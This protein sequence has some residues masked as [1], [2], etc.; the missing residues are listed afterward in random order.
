M[1]SIN[2]FFENL[3]IPINDQII[4]NL[5]DVYTLRNCTGTCKRWKIVVN[6]FLEKNPALKTEFNLIEK[7]KKSYSIMIEGFKRFESIEFFDHNHNKNEYLFRELNRELN[8]DSLK[9]KKVEVIKRFLVLN[10]NNLQ[11]ELKAQISLSYKENLDL[12]RF[13]LEIGI[14]PIDVNSSFNEIKNFIVEQITKHTKR[15]AFEVKDWI[16]LYDFDLTQ[17][18]ENSTK[19]LLE[20]ILN[21]LDKEKYNHF[22]DNYDYIRTMIDY[23]VQCAYNNVNSGKSSNRSIKLQDIGKFYNCFDLHS[24][25]LW[26]L[27]KNSPDLND[28]ANAYKKLKFVL[29]KGIDSFPGQQQFCNVCTF[30]AQNR[31]NI[32]NLIEH[33]DYLESAKANYQKHPSYIEEGHKIYG[34]FKEGLLKVLSLDKVNEC[35][36]AIAFIANLPTDLF[37]F[38]LY[39]N[40]LE[41]K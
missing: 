32:R 4:G 8:S 30:F 38:V 13:L 5:N 35:V 21:A 28:G 15:S 25:E 10:N 18:S 2:G 26:Q 22:L 7:I 17:C 1:N 29:E 36:F 33:L 12:A 41:E 9:L 40:Y 37:N 24:L 11:K 3:P 20:E 23:L 39:L 34:Q 6:D 31:Q 16:K 19:C 14:R 27:P